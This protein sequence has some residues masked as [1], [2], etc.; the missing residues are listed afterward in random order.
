[1]N[2]EAIKLTQQ[3]QEELV[4]LFLESDDFWAYRTSVLAG[5]S[6]REYDQRVKQ[7]AS[8]HEVV[9]SL[10]VRVKEDLQEESGEPAGARTVCSRFI[11]QQVVEP[12]I[13]KYLPQLTGHTERFWSNVSAGMVEIIGLFSEQPNQSIDTIL[14]NYKAKLNN[15][16]E[17][18]ELIRNQAIPVLLLAGADFI[19][20]L[21]HRLLPL[22]ELACQQSEKQ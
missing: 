3:A 7:A 14:A 19:G 17:V 2:Q 6:F 12:L 15:P 10:L 1:M 22:A 20:Q 21:C 4:Q 11:R 9:I 5:M 13:F 16:E 8:R 18:K